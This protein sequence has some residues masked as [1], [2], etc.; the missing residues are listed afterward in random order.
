M[1]GNV[2]TVSETNTLISLIDTAN[3]RQSITEKKFRQGYEGQ[4]QIAKKVFECI[5]M[6]TSWSMSQICS[7]M[8]RKGQG[9]DIRIIQGCV[10]TLVGSGLVKEIPKGMFKRLSVRTQEKNVHETQGSIQIINEPKEIIVT[11]KNNK[12]PLEML[13]LISSSARKLAD[14]LDDAALVIASQI[15]DIESQTSKLKQLQALLKSIGAE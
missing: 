10:N 13:S 5:P 9:S 14:D 8:N 7:E 4:T 6:T 3:D 1:K 12:D 15:K 11:E 2:K